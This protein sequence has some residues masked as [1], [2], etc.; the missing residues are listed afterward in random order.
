MTAGGAKWGPEA[1]TY[2]RHVG[3]ALLGMPRENMARDEAAFF[4]A[5]RDTL[6]MDACRLDRVAPTLVYAPHVPDG[7]WPVLAAGKYSSDVFGVPRALAAHDTA[8]LRRA[9]AALEAFARQRTASGLLDTRSV[10]AAYAYL[11]LGD[12]S[13]ALRMARFFVDSSMA[14]MSIASNFI[15][16]L[17]PVVGAPLWPRMMLMRA[18][19]A[20]AAK[21]TEEAA[22]WY[23]SVLSLWANADTEL[24]PEVARIRA[25][26]AKLQAP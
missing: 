16:G 2:Q 21:Q 18:D 20:A 12:S 17:V 25:A 11:A 1:V 23:D 26:R 14:R 8:M 9:A 4:V 5:I 10:V 6:C 24:Q 15:T 3:R 19:L 7:T 13:S 22:K